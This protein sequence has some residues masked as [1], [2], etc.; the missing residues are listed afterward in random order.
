MPFCSVQL[1][2]KKPINSAYPKE[3]NTLGDHIRKHRLDLGLTQKNVAAT[4]GVGELVVNGWEKHRFSP[5]PSH[6]PGIITFLGYTPSPYDKVGDNVME[7][8][9]LY[10]LTHGMSQ[11]KF[12]KLL[13]VD[14]KTVAMWEVGKHTPS[15]KLVERFLKLSPGLFP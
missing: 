12:A 4:L 7:K 5:Q 11:M 6:L 10:R 2:A 13:S 14:Q 9:K 1:T 3:L 15:M 8:M